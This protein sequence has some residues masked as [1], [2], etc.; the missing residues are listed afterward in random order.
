MPLKLW[1]KTGGSLLHIMSKFGA[2]ILSGSEVI[3]IFGEI[4]LHNSYKI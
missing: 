1:D 2:Y 3:L 4:H